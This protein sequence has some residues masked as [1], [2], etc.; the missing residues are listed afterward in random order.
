MRATGSHGTF[1]PNIDLARD[2]DGV[3]LERLLAR[4]HT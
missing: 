3:E 4:I 1:A 2:A